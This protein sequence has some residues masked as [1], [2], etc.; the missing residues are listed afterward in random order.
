MA[1]THRTLQLSPTD[2]FTSKLRDYYIL[3]KPEV[4][5]LILMTT[6]A[7]YYL[8]SRGPCR[9][10]GLMNTLLVRSWSPAVLDGQMCRTARRPLPSGRLD[11]RKAFRL[12]PLVARWEDPRFTARPLGVR[13]GSPATIEAITKAECPLG[14]WRN[15]NIEVPTL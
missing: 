12:I 15:R 7:G 14:L 11:A 13:C 3:T 1:T 10:A 2:R 4:N 6:S 8:A 5:L 9:I